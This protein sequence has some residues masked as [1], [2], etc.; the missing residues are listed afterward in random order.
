MNTPKVPRIVFFFFKGGGGLLRIIM[1]IH[2][3][4]MSKLP[5]ERTD[6][7]P[8]EKAVKF[9]EENAKSNGKLL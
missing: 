7:M 8:R 5:L 3:V 6:C 1:H 4:K 2:C 9:S